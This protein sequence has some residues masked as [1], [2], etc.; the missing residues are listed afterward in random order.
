MA[1]K[2]YKVSIDTGKI[3]KADIYEDKTGRKWLNVDVIINDELDKYDKI[4]A[5]K[6]YN[7][8]TKKSEFIGS[9]KEFNS[10][11]KEET[12]DNTPSWL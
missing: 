11:P 4:G 1:Y 2:I 7:K 12:N 9:V 5:V 3:N 10:K 6:Q 8:E